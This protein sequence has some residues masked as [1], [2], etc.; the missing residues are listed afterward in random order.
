M[1]ASD[2]ALLSVDNMKETFPKVGGK[3][4]LC[5]CNF[6]AELGIIP[7]TTNAATSFTDKKTQE[8]MLKKRT[9]ASCKSLKVVSSKRTKKK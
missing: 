8:N 5:M 6:C 2:E 9:K 1:C 3:T 4:P 7:P